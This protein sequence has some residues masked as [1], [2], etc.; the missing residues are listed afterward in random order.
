M[1]FL[2]RLFGS[3]G[4]DESAPK[5]AW[6]EPGQGPFDVEKIPGEWH[7]QVTFD[8]VIAH[9]EEDRVAAFVELLDAEDGVQQAAHEDREVILI[10]ARGMSLLKAQLTAE[11]AW[12]AADRAANTG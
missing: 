3:R 1:S 4:D 10:K 5:P 11:R 9:E 8:D 12:D 6:S 2:R 7:F